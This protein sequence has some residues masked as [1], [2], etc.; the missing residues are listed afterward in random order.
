MTNDSS[1]MELFFKF[2]NGQR[3]T[4]DTTTCVEDLAATTG[5]HALAKSAGL[6]AFFAADAK[7]DFHGM[8][9]QLSWVK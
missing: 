4:S 8:E 5:A 3:V 9:V 2:G 6:D 7:L 1:A